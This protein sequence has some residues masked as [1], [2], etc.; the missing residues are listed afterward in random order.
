MLKKEF[1]KELEDRLQML[2]EKER[3]DMIEEYSQHISMRMESGMKEEEAIDDFGNIDDLIAEILDAYHLDPEYE[4]KNKGRNGKTGVA[5]LLPKDFFEKRKKK[6][7]ERDLKKN[8]RVEA[9]ERFK[10]N[11]GETIENIADKARKTSGSAISWSW[12][13]VKKIFLIF[14]KVVLICLVVPAAFFDV[15]GL[16]SLGT[17]SV[18]AFQGYPVIGCVIVALGAVL[19]MTAYILFLFSYILKGK[20]VNA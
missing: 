14:V 1:L 5:D 12:D 3:K 10:E 6:S 13:K 19:S 2:N 8:K 11:R 15:A 20:G 4:V 17:L 9:M 7:K 16:V 18:M